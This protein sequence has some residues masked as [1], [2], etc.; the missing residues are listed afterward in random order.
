MT[1]PMNP[2]LRPENRNKLIAK[3]IQAISDKQNKII[4]Q[5][6][7]IIDDVG[8]FEKNVHQQFVSYTG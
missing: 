7:K 8:A 2:M 6:D 3:A 1:K 4:E 5:A